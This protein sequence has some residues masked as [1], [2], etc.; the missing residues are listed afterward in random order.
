MKRLLSRTGPPL[1][2]YYAVTLGLPLANGGGGSLFVEHAVTVL[3]VPL[4]LIL[5]FC[6]LRALCGFRVGQA[7]GRPRSNRSRAT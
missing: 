3:A 4:V 2:V 6:A 7:A 1:A 5:A